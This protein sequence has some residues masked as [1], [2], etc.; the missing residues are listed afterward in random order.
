LEKISGVA[1]HQGVVVSEADIA[2]QQLSVRHAL[3]VE[4]QPLSLLKVYQRCAS[5]VACV[6]HTTLTI[7]GKIKA[8]EYERYM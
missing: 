5:R 8:Q 7:P 2:C 4:T 3:L 1:I 6:G